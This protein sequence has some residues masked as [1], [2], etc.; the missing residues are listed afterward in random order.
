MSGRI[1]EDEENR[2]GKCIILA[3]EQGMVHAE[4]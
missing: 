4:C 1:D 3:D 2:G